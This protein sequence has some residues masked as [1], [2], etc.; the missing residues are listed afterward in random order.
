MLDIST[1]GQ[2]SSDSTLVQVVKR[3]DK[4]AESISVL[5]KQG[6]F[7]DVFDE[8]ITWGI[9]FAGKLLIAFLIFF[10]GRWLIR[11]FL[12]FQR[13]IWARR[14]MDET[15]RSFLDNLLSIAAYTALIILIINIVGAQTVSFAALVASA[16]LAIGLALKDNLANFAG[17]VMLLFNKPFKN[18]DFIE[19]QNLSGTVK[20]IGILYT[21]LTS[22]DNKTIFIP[23]GPLS[24]GNIINYNT[25]ITRRIDITVSVDYGSDVDKV[26][27]ILMDIMHKHAKILAD[28]QPFARMIKMNDS[29]IDFSLRAW[30]KTADYW[31]VTYDLNEEIYNQLNA[32]GLNI[33]FPQMTVHIAK[34]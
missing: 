31:E 32:F 20:A 9:T 4:S 26:K 7:D 13:K 25:Q 8:I 10:I 1:I 30:T 27:S 18:G 11:K 23:N 5:I 19:A 14:N 6:R 21:T 12:K 29:S 3:A 2:V 22:A 24:T 17:G 34:D 15:L 28:P 33:P 16:G